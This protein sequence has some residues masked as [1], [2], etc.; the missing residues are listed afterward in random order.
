M[1]HEIE[2]TEGH[3]PPLCPYCEVELTHVEF[4]RQ[5]LSFGFMSGFTWV[6]LLSCPH[7]RK[8]LGT[9]S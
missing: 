7:C 6:V 8:V 1:S 5:K 3:A 2:F 4:L 9:Q